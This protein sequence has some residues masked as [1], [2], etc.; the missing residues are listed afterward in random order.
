M[1]RDARVYIME[2]EVRTYIMK[3]I[4]YSTKRGTIKN[5]TGVMNVVTA[6]SYLCSILLINPQC[7]SSFSLFLIL[8]DC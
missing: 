7:A 4:F 6:E 8:L 2:V 1:Q 5:K 3:F